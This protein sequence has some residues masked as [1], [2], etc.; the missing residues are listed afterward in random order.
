MRLFFRGVVCQ[1]QQSATAPGSASSFSGVKVELQHLVL[2]ILDDPVVSWVFGDAGFCS[3]DIKLAILRPPP[4]IL[5]FPRAA[6]CPPLFLCNFSSGDGFEATLTS[7]QLVFPFDAAT[8]L[9]SDSSEENCRRIGEILTRKMSRRN[10]MMVSIAAGEA[11]SRKL[12]SSLLEVYHGRLWLMG[13][14][15]TYE[16]YMKFLSKHPMPDKDWDLQLLPITSV[17]T[18]I[19]GSIPRSPR[20]T[21]VGVLSQSQAVNPF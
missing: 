14:S 20:Y 19:G 10:P 12:L 3:T 15:A 1:Q 18:S 5:R 6:R 21:V 11:D 4:P 7:G 9:C 8:Q 16:T 17:C 13:W 2:A